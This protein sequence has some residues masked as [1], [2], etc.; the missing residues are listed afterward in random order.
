M[1]SPIRADQLKPGQRVSLDPA[2][3]GRI[4]A[5]VGSSKRTLVRIVWTDGSE[6]GVARNERL[7]LVAEAA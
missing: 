3:N 2:G 6:T 4:V 7:Y 5:A 1:S